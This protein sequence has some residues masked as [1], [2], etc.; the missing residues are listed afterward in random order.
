MTRLKSGAPESGAPSGSRRHLRTVLACMVLSTAWIV[1][2]AAGS[3]TLEGWGPGPA[4][5]E[6][7][8][9][10]V[11]AWTSKGETLAAVAL[12][13]AMEDEVPVGV[14]FSVA[15][16]LA[17]RAAHSVEGARPLVFF[18]P[19][20]L[21]VG[22]VAPV[23]QE[24]AV[25]SAM[26]DLLRPKGWEEIR[27]DF[28]RHRRKRREDSAQATVSAALLQQLFPHGTHVRRGA[29]ADRPWAQ[30]HREDAAALFRR[31]RFAPWALRIAGP[32]GVAA[33]AYAALSET[34]DA[35]DGVASSR[36]RGAESAGTERAR[37][38]DA[39]SPHRLLWIADDADV[40][41]ESDGE[42]SI[43]VGYRLPQV[44]ERD[45]FVLPVLLSALSEGQGSLAQRLNVAVRGESAPRVEVV[46]STEGVPALSMVVT[47]PAADAVRAWRVMR[48]LSHSLSDLPF[49]DAAVLH[50]RRRVDARVEAIRRDAGALLEA[51]LADL[52]GRWPPPDRWKSPVR[53]ADLRRTVRSLFSRDEQ[54]AV[55]LGSVPV[56]LTSSPEFEHAT[57]I[58]R[59]AF[60]PFSPDLGVQADA[61]ARQTHDE[62]LWIR[63]LLER[64]GGDLLEAELPVYRA[65]YMSSEAAPWGRVEAVVDFDG[66]SLGSGVGLRSGE[67]RWETGGE[68]LPGNGVFSPHEAV[69]SGE[70]SVSEIPVPGRLEALRFREPVL[71][72]TELMRSEAPRTLFDVDCDGG[73]CRALRAEPVPGLI[74]VMVTDPDSGLPIEVQTWWPDG[75]GA[76]EPDEVARIEGWSVFDGVM[77]VRDFDLVDAVGS[78]S[79]KLHLTDWQWISKPKDD[80]V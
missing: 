37:P 53:A 41:D 48:A 14:A 44:S 70:A 1:Q 8:S 64:L 68:G 52:P 75:A 59:E 67:M 79:R 40:G 18:A 51:A 9:G 5:E 47:V 3:G 74:V 36:K 7:A 35:D 71:L 65:S 43:G 31:V 38:A 55:I 46:V 66:E 19:N 80:D 61:P 77:V 63:E 2:P 30:V 60:D 23:G 25:W 34:V 17:H 32:P 69:P 11:S 12:W 29:Y 15:Y 21:A 72:L 28:E 49:R 26:P 78:G 45:R 4:D 56:S 76:A 73:S 62:D 6:I 57:R 50:A 20:G 42:C 58:S 22:M 39:A 16:V 24:R 33:R 13:P 10:A 27:K 54:V